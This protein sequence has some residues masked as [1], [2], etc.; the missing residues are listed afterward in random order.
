MGEAEV[1]EEQR[2]A[3]WQAMQ[4]PSVV[5]LIVVL[6]LC[7]SVCV[8]CWVMNITGWVLALW[9]LPCDNARELRNWLFLY[10]ACS[11]GEIC[12][13][14]LVRG[15][16]E[17]VTE[18]LDSRVRPGFTRAC[19]ICYTVTSSALKIFWC[20]HVQVMVGSASDDSGCG[21]SLPRFMGWYSY[22]LLL[23][24]VAVDTFL[25]LFAGLV[26]RAVA[27][28]LHPT[29]RGAKP[30]T[31][32]RM[33]V[34]EYQAGLF[35]DEN[36]PTDERPQKECC[37]CLEEYSSDCQIVRTPCQHLMHRACL[38]RWL[39]QSHVCPICRGELEEGHSAS[40]EA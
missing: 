4:R 7:V 37:F 35:A 22:I 11:M 17:K 18:G 8:C 20:I 30:G 10:L 34:V 33:E 26:L 16:V 29:A 38:S 39:Q 5:L 31:L 40:Q 28:S 3:L 36:D 1:H 9:L 27:S 24:L 19:Y 23:R 15:C 21:E 13:A 2:H 12:F 6:L 25:H 32:E 14:H